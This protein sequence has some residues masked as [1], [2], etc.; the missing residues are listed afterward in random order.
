MAGITLTQAQ[1]NLDKWMTIAA[2]LSEALTVKHEGVL[3]TRDNLDSI[4]KMID[5]WEKKVNRL[6]RGSGISVQRIVI[7]D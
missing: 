1:E 4:T 3:H 7:C 5:Y 2:G 6:S